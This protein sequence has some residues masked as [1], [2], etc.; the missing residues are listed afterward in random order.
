MCTAFHPD[1]LTP[2]LDGL[3]RC[4]QL[5]FMRTATSA[6]LGEH[7]R[8][9]RILRAVL[10]HPHARSVCI[11]NVLLEKTTYYR[12][13]SLCHL[14]RPETDALSSVTF[15]DTTLTETEAHQRVTESLMENM[16][17]FSAEIRSLQEEILALLVTSS[18]CSRTLFVTKLNEFLK[19]W[20]TMVWKS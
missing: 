20:K 11:S 18:D 4:V 19:V 17:K 7:A 2:L 6:T 8:Q 5:R 12:L 13:L 14:R 15:S 16:R 9:L 10:C 1:H 3:V